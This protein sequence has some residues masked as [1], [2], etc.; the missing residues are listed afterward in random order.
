MQHK[1]FSRFSTLLHD[2]V[3]LSYPLIIFL[4]SFFRQSKSSIRYELVLLEWKPPGWIFLLHEFPIY[5]Q[6]HAGVFFFFSI[7]RTIFAK[8]LSQYN[9]LLKYSKT[10]VLINISDKIDTIFT[11]YFFINLIFFHQFNF[12]NLVDSFFYKNV[13]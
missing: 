6:F 2:S 10:F 7:Y 5:M 12:A 13:D 8:H 4:F 11:I 1:C 3:Y 9:T